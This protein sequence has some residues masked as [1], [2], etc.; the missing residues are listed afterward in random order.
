MEIKVQIPEEIS[1]E[2]LENELSQVGEALNLD[3]IVR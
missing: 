3:I 2:H 1:L